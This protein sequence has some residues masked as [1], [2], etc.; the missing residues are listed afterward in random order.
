MARVFRRMVAGAL[1][2][3][4]AVGEI[5][6]YVMMCV[7]VCARDAKAGDGRTAQSGQDGR[8]SA[9]YSNQYKGDHLPQGLAL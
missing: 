6:G 5:D 9:R 4:C 3:L 2:R 1:S 7:R 8:G